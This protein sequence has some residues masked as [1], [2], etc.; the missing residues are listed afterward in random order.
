ML[1]RVIVGRPV[2]LACQILPLRQYHLK[3]R[4]L[5]PQGSPLK[6]C[7][8]VRRKTTEAGDDK[9][10]HINAGPNEGILFL[11]N[12]FPLKLRWL[13]RLPFLNV[14]KSVPELLK[15]LN[16]PRIGAADPLSIIQKALPKDLPIKVTEVL[17][18][19]KEGGAFVKFSHEPHVN[20]KE[21]EGTLQNY[22]KKNP[23]KPWF[24]PWRRVRTFLVKGRPWVEDLYRFP[25]SRL[26][27]EFLPIEPG[28]EAAELSQE[29][30]YSIFRRY[31]KLADIIAQ[32]VDSKVTPKFAFLN[33]R[34][35]RHAIMAKNCMHGFVLPGSEG[36]GKAG[37][38]IRLMY[39]Q[40]MKGHWI[41][42]WIVNHPRITIPLI[43]AVLATVTAAAFDPIRT[44][45]IKAHV[46]HSFHI[47]DNKY[48]KWL[49]SQVT[50][51][52]DLLSFKRRKADDAGLSVIWD[53]RKD[54]IE[55]IQAWL[56]ETADTFVVIQ[57]PR[58]SGK[59]E[60]VIDQAL[61]H[62]RNTLVVDCKPIQEARG[63]SATI[64]AT[65]N[66]VGYK[67]VFS[68]INN[69]SSLVDLAAQGTIGTK[70][71]FSETL[72]TQLDKIFQNTATALK[73]IALAD[74]TKED[75][76]ADIGD[77]EYL[78]AHPERR[79]VV[80]ID[81]F[82]HKS[83][84]SSTVYD[85][86]SQ[87]AA[88]LT[89]G[90]VAHVIFLTNDVSFTKSLSKALP[91]R[92]FRQITLGDCSPEVAK[93]YVIHQ[94]EA[95]ASDDPAD[96]DDKPP[97]ASFSSSSSSRPPATDGTL[98]ELDDCIETLGGRLTELEF[99]ARRIKAGQTPAAAVREII[100]QSASEILKL[101]LL[102]LDHG[103]G[104]GSS[105]PRSWT[106]AQAWDLIRAL[107]RSAAASVP[108]HALLL[109]S[110]FA[111]AGETALR[112]LE[113]AELITILSANGRPHAV[114]PGKPVYHAAFRS[115]VAD[116][117]LSARLDLAVLA[118]GKR[119]DE[120]VIGD[121]EEEM[122]LLARLG[123]VPQGLE[124]RV[125]CLVERVR[126][127]QE[128]VEGGE[129]E[130]GRLKALLRKEGGVDT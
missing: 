92:V 58:G 47:T 38:V 9:S 54:D 117:V 8:G 43:A 62:R 3:S 39:E 108:Y 81:N 99:L 51:A 29:T 94:L 75:K 35:V 83:N 65:A 26:R 18:R 116:A 70:T 59:K 28:G 63:D 19:L 124:A 4:S 37:T 111:T 95:E 107:A 128:R 50:R 5:R 66:Q 118:E 17:P 33:F 97:T 119:V 20:A 96:G 103:G 69:I 13:L 121:A 49:M 22:L 42:D 71:G 126:D 55:Q 32:P 24:N 7:K 68:F 115:L 23:I 11:D 114:R 27:V 46:T 60:L 56:M 34:L 100:D 125:R 14:D 89:T 48:Y 90:N 10:G 85:K 82:L 31:G 84:E 109:S 110:P 73:Q 57:G 36:G 1:S 77:D 79:P 21:I 122:V 40:K 98:A 87:W 16:S 86:I 130:G 129:R 78:E 41:R 102:D 6:I 120:R 53:E 12:V 88:G 74:R 113:Q 105:S 52:N 101:Y 2:G 76:D 93:R 44:F 72:D 123:H 61:K 80:V 67:P 104:G 45:F 15:R 91:D 64:G 127:A 25:S 106:A 30:L 112:A